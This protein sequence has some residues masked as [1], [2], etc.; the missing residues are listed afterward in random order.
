MFTNLSECLSF[1]LL[2]LY[3]QGSGSYGRLYER[4]SDLKV[5]FHTTDFIAIAQ[6]AQELFVNACVELVKY[7]C[8]GDF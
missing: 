3:E 2:N 6:K 7:R 8:T 5:G 1:C 4:G